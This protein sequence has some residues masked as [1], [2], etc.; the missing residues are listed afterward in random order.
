A[1]FNLQRYCEGGYIRYAEECG[2]LNDELERLI[3]EAHTGV[4]ADAPDVPDLV[5]KAL[6]ALKST[7]IP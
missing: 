6:F 3:E 4:A 1:R 5:G 7:G 2:Y